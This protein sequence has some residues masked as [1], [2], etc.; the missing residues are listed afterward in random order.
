[1]VVESQ[2]EAVA[3]SFETKHG[4]LWWPI[5][6]HDEFTGTENDHLGRSIQGR[7]FE[8]LALVWGWA[9]LWQ[10][11]Q[12]VSIQRTWRLVFCVSFCRSLCFIFWRHVVPW[13]PACWFGFS[14][15]NARA[16]HPLIIKVRDVSLHPDCDRWF[17]I[18]KMSLIPTVDLILDPPTVDLYWAKSNSLDLIILGLIKGKTFPSFSLFTLCLSPSPFFLYCFS[19]LSFLRAFY[20]LNRCCIGL[21]KGMAF[22]FFFFF[23]H[24]LLFVFL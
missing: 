7:Y 20:P 5:Q 10:V 15:F 22:P 19:G 3:T 17:K 12:G 8:P 18:L 4:N 13:E 6:G 14:V 24:F 2:R 1:M 23:F 16:A 9:E 11:R 21:I